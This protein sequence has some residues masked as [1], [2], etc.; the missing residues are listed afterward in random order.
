MKYILS[1][2]IMFAFTSICSSQLNSFGLIIGGGYTVINVQK[3]VDPN[4]LSD[5]NNYGLVFKGYAEYQISEDK[6]LGLEIGRNRLYYWE[7]PAPGYSW[8][9]WRTEWTTNAV[10]YLSKHFGEK[11]FIQIGPGIHIFYNGTVL[12]LLGS[13]GT[14]FPISNNFS[15]P[16]TFRIEPVFGSGTPVAINIATGIRF[17]LVK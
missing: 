12:G 15:I 11:F 8:Y 2:V 17:K 13:V 14:S 16:L 9:N 4:P 5:W 10:V 1:V 7:Y 6:M 3:V